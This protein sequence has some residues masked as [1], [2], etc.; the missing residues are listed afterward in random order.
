VCAQHISRS[1]STGRSLNDFKRQLCDAFYRD[2]SSTHPE[3][4]SPESFACDLA[5]L[6]AKLDGKGIHL[7]SKPAVPAPQ[8]GTQLRR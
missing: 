8:R 2:W 3:N 5:E 1:T 4:L 6:I 7:V